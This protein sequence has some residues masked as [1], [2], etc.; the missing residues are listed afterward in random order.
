MFLALLRTRSIPHY[1]QA[2]SGQKHI[3]AHKHQLFCFDLTYDNFTQ[4][5][6]RVKHIY[7][8]VPSHAIKLIDIIASDIKNNQLVCNYRISKF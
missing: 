8:H 4:V 7:R 3:Y 5:S 2:K 1:T 6:T